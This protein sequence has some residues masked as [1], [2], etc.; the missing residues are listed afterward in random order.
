[1]IEVYVNF[2]A[3][4][5]ELSYSSKFY[6]DII[7]LLIKCYVNLTPKSLQIKFYGME[8]L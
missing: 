8:I 1:M 6:K 2:C 3:K 5:F 7:K 4:S